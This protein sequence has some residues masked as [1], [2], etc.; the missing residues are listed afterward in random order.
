MPRPRTPP[1]RAGCT[2]SSPGAR[3]C[4]RP[5]HG[6]QHRQ[7]RRLTLPTFTVVLPHSGVRVAL[8]GVTSGRNSPDRGLWDDGLA[9]S[10]PPTRG[11]GRRNDLWG[12]AMDLRFALFERIARDSVLR[13]L[14]VNYADRLDDPAVL[15]RAGRRHLL[16]DHGVDDRRP[17]EYVVR[18]RVT[19]RS[20][21]HTSA[22]FRG[23]FL[24]RCR[25]ASA[26]RR[27]GRGRRGRVDHGPAPGDVA[28]CRTGP[29]PTRSSRP[30]STTWLP[31]RDEGAFPSRSITVRSVPYLRTALLRIAERR[32][33]RRAVLHPCSSPGDT[34]VTGVADHGML[35]VYRTW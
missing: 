16:S 28:G 13:R 34:P 35:I 29:G 26:G 21:A 10:C 11:R 14:L 7:A 15:L 20:C 9:S 3:N 19:D 32:T 6:G 25:T 1:Q 33:A 22:S 5:L 4:L 27:P 18:G 12:I 24:S 2:R 8:V 17:D 31:Y 23:A 30:G